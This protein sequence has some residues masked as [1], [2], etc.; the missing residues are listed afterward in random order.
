MSARFLKKH[1]SSHN[2]LRI[3]WSCNFKVL[4]VSQQSPRCSHLTCNKSSQLMQFYYFAE[5]W[6]RSWEVS[7]LWFRL[8]N[9]DFSP[10]D[11][12]LSWHKQSLNHR[13]N[14]LMADVTDPVVDE[15]DFEEVGLDHVVKSARPCL[16]ENGNVS[17]VGCHFQLL[18]VLICVVKVCCVVAV[19]LDL[20][21]LSLK[22]RVWPLRLSLAGSLSHCRVLKDFDFYATTDAQLQ[23]QS[24]SKW[25][26]D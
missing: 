10:A 26:A 14:P 15:D 20:L 24:V 6:R 8:R 25:I 22:K 19:L 13:P 17:R 9:C 12:R 23:I 16:L 2:G 1:F 3:L 18:W 11:T 5:V 7:T 21:G 4:H